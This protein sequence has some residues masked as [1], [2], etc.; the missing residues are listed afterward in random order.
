MRAGTDTSRFYS[1]GKGRVS[2]AAGASNTG[3]EAQRR[4][5]DQYGNL[6]RFRVRR[7]GS[8]QRPAA[9][10]HARRQRL[11][12]Q[13]GADTMWGAG[14]ARASYIQLSQPP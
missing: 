8:R 3:G 9:T 4:V 7:Q 14:I 5:L 1:D 11:L 10:P 2:L 12:R 13:G 6:E